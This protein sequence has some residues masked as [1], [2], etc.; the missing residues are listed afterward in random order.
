MENRSSSHLTS[1][2][3][4]LMAVLLFMSCDFSQ[5]PTY[6]KDEEVKKE[7]SIINSLGT[8]IEVR[9][10]APEDFRRNKVAENSYAH[11]LRNLPLHKP[12]KKVELY[13]GNLKGNQNAQAAVIKMDVGS[14]DLQQCADAIMRLRAEYLYKQ[15]RY[16][17]LHFNFTNGFNAK[18]SHWRKGK[19]L[20]INGNRVSWVTSSK[21]NGSYESFRRYMN[22][23]FMFAGTASLEKELKQKPLKEIE[24]G[25]VFIKGGHPGHAVIVVDVCEHKNGDKAFMLAQSYM[26]AQEIHVLKNPSNEFISP[27]YKVNEIDE[28]VVTPEWTFYSN[29]LRTFE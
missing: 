25:D 29:Q 5:E 6:T 4:I 9:F 20:S 19:G 27:W 17:D 21:S 22:K 18:Y 11:Y 24:A 15:K 8:T 13:D 26:P 23:V 12:G 10:N 28:M 3:C 16:A 1:M 7:E 2:K 14:Q